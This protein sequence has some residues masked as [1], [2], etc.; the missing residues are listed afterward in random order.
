M[1]FNEFFLQ[2]GPTLE[3]VLKETVKI[4]FCSFVNNIDD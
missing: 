4:F 3:D 2:D 1:K